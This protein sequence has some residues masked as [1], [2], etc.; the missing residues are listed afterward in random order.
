MSEKIRNVVGP[1]VRRFRTQRELS[2]SALAVRL[3]LAGYDVSRVGVA[4]IESQ[5]LQVTDAE[6]FVLARVLK[7]RMDE[8]FPSGERVKRFLVSEQSEK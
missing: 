5:I 6:L 2:Q 3:Q 8:L 1:Q 7:V 4:K